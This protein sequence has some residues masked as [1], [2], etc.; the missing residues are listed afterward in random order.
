VYLRVED[1][2]LGIPEEQLATI[3]EPFVQVDRRSTPAVG[4][5]GL[6]LTISR[7]L[8]RRM[9]GEI[10]VESTVGV[11]SAFVVWLPVAPLESLRTGGGA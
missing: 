1:T 5:T 11:G 8:A 10:S 2:G 7:R 4:G 3:F 6:G 9:A